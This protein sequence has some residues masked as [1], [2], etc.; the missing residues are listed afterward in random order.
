[1][2]KV[3]R[4]LD[5]IEDFL[6]V[7]MFAAMVGVI[8]VQVIMRYI[9]NNSLSWSEEFGRIPLRLALLVRHQH[10]RPEEGTHLDHPSG[11]PAPAVRPQD[12]G[13]RFRTGDHR[14]LPGNGVL[15]SHP[16]RQ[17]GGHTVRG[18]PD[19]HVLGLPLRRGG[20]R[21][22]DVPGHPGH[23]GNLPGRGCRKSTRRGK[24]GLIMGMTILFIALFVMLMI[25]VPVGFAIGGATMI[26]M[27][28]GSDLNM[29]I[30]AQYCYSGISSFTVMAIPFFML[31]GIIMSTGGIARRI[32]NFASALI[33]FVTGALGCVTVLS[34]MFFGALSGSGMA[35]TSAIGGMMIPEMKR[36][37]Y[38]P[39]Y[40]A[41]LV[42]F[43]GI[44]GPIIP[45]SL[46]FVLYGATTGT[47]VPKLFL[48][49]ILPGIFLGLV[50]LGMNIYMCNRSG[51]DLH[52]GARSRNRRPESTR[53][54]IPAEPDQEDRRRDQGWILGPPVP[55]DHPGRNLLR[56]IHPHGS[57][58]RLGD[59]LHPGQPLRLPGHE[60][61]GLVRGAAGRGGLERDH[62]L[63][64][65]VF[66]RIFDLHD[67]REGSPDDHG[68]PDHVLRTIPT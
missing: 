34:C 47:P 45:P 13:S 6:L 27:F 12:R 3:I 33:D 67:L 30:S 42:C 40:A 10:R 50:F 24:G 53:Q 28:L 62:V 58:L 61:G 19:Q 59:L 49:G 26:A 4:I 37:G 60:A 44:V 32:V 55:G 48:G 31:A 52:S 15:R 57:R 38:D 17:P 41:T 43:G 21:T 36:K 5:R 1:M 35:T 20:L 56:D 16:G 22:H 25:G 18:H 54:G 68:A 8:F 64:P 11:R 63:P 65:G 2:K 7:S 46:S 66:H 23:P 29:V 9:F 14:H 39:P 51:T